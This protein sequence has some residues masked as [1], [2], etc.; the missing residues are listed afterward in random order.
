[1]LSF[2]NRYVKRQVLFRTLQIYN[3]FLKSEAIDDTLCNRLSSTFINFQ[4]I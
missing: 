1:M 4:G 3:N 2:E